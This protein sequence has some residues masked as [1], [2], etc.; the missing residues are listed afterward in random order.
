MAEK[1]EC[2][3]CN[4]TVS[5]KKSRFVDGKVYCVT[6][7]E[8]KIKTDAKERAKINPEVL[9]DIITTTSNNIEGHNIQEYLGIV[10]HQVVLG[11]N[12]WRDMLGSIRRGWGG[13]SKA[14]ERE[15]SSG[16]DS[17]V[18]GL[19]KEAYLAGANGIIAI[20]VT[21]SM[22]VAGELTKSNDKMMVVSAT[23]T[24]VKMN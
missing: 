22:E 23:G 16:F 7:A 9:K 5:V 20:S 1:V 10:N 8:K 6:C 19:V 24:A 3:S 2:V 17:A 14:L 15:L 12:A 18:E 13:R 21:S 4:R 11:V